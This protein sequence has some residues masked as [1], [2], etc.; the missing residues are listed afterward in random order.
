MPGRGENPQRTT[1][2]PGRNRRGPR[3]LVA[4]TGFEAS[5][6]AES[7]GIPAEEAAQ[8]LDKARDLISQ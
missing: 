3:D 1:G 5:D 2:N 8:I 4:L 6:I 7:M